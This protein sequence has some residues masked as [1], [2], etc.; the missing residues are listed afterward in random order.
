MTTPTVLPMQKLSTP[1]SFKA[2][3]SFKNLF[4]SLS[5]NARFTVLAGVSFAV[6]LPVLGVLDPKVLWAAGLSDANGVNSAIANME[7]AL[8]SMAVL[9]L[10][11]T[12]GIA[13]LALAAVGFIGQLRKASHLEVDGLE[14]E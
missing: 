10:F 12:G 5:K 14:T 2:V 8:R 7:A 9:E 13:V 6:T 3:T 4:G 11:A 1:L